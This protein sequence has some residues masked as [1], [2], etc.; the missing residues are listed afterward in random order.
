MEL[1]ITTTEVGRTVRRDQ[2]RPGGCKRVSGDHLR[3]V[4][5]D[6]CDLVRDSW[7]YNVYP[8]AEALGAIERDRASLA[9]FVSRDPRAAKLLADYFAMRVADLDLVEATARDLAARICEYPWHR[10][11]PK[12]LISG[13]TYGDQ[14]SGFAKVTL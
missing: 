13:A 10:G 2:A 7:N 4:T 5:D 9:A 14:P 8:L 12:H 11:Y 1:L 6:A 3:R